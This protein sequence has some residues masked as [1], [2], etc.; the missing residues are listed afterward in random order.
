MLVC[1]L[2]LLAKLQLLLVI[3]NY[4]TP[5]LVCVGQ[6]NKIF[7]CKSLLSNIKHFLYTKAKFK[8]TKSWCNEP[9]GCF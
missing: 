6:F 8:F 1:Q 3:N 4:S 9:L 5:E 7:I 2:I